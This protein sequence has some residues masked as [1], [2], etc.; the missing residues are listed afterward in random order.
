M[1]GIKNL[2][3]SEHGIFGVL[4]IVGA[5][6]LCALK[7]MTVEDWKNFA[8]VIFVTFAG[9]H[10]I[11]SGANSIATRG[12]PKATAQASGEEKKS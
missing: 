8:Q 7:I 9:A 3:S 10:A 4:L 11:V 6:V 1:D 12:V 5:T 2:L